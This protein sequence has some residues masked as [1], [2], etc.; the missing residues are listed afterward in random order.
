MRREGLYEWMW[1]LLNYKWLYKCRL[2]WY[3]WRPNVIHG[4]WRAGFGRNRW[5]HS[6]KG[7]G[8][9]ETG[10]NG[11]F[12][13]KTKGKK[14]YIGVISKGLEFGSAKK[15]KKQPKRV[16]YKTTRSNFETSA[17]RLRNGIF[18]SHIQ[19]TLARE[20]AG[21]SG[22]GVTYGET[23]EFWISISFPLVVY[24]CWAGYNFKMF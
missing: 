1:T 8:F 22:R 3:Q 5:L 18:L 23:S 4:I 10:K 2:L 11:S 6:R 24:L 12:K 17:R 14:S 19:W 21:R 9:G 13:I 20:G 7:G 15:Q 16:N